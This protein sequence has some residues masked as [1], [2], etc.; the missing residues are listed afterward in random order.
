MTTETHSSKPLDNRI[1]PPSL[2]RRYGSQLGIIGVGIAM[3][4]AFVIAAP[5]V[6]TNIDIYVAFAETTPVFGI[7]AL[8][9]TFV[10]ITGEIDLRFPSIMALGTAIFAI[11]A[12]QWGMPWYVSLVFAFAAGGICGLI[13]GVLVARLNIPSLVITIGTQFLFRG[14]ELVLMNGTGVPLTEDVYPE[15]HA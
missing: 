6:F 1:A 5:M 11:S 7:I 14:L 8:A 2:L 15:L 13:N 4:L 3:W 10:V 9:L 12:T